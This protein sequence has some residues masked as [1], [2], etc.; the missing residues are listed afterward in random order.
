MKCLILAG[1]F[2]TR[3]WPL[4]RDKPKP[5]L[6]IKGKSV[7]THIIEKV[8]DELN[9]V[10]S[11]NKKFEKDFI[12]WKKDLKRNVELLVENVTENKE[13]LGAVGGLNYFI[14]KKKVK[15]DL[16]IISG[17]NYFEF[18]LRDFLAFY[19]NKPLI[20]IYDIHKKN[21]AKEYGV[22][23]VKNSKIVELKEKPE[24]PD[25]TLISTGVYILPSRCFNHLKYF[26]S[27][28]RPDNLGGFFKY[29]I[30]KED[31]ISWPFDDP[32]FDIGNFKTYLEAHI[33]STK[34][35]IKE[36]GAEIINSFLNGSVF[37]GEGAKIINSSIKN[38]IVMNSSIVEYSTIENSIIDAE[39]IVRNSRISFELV[40]RGAFVIDDE[41]KR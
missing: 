39:S 10:V 32:W 7:I 14:Q 30:E 37:I 13:K 31:V 19:R 34:G 27:T 18:S 38:S 12:E 25:T 41:Y 16:L 35:I 28:R 20:A 36:K 8:P 5:L 9:V 6:K 1:G 11:I 24:N 40:S 4:T 22:V 26:C 33:K 3:L 21:K 15:D 2:G 17:D 29:L 23:K